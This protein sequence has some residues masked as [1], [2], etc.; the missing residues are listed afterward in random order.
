M[1]T[2]R[3]K[4]TGGSAITSEIAVVSRKNFLLSFF[5]IVHDYGFVWVFYGF[6]WI[7]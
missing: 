4:L 6:S 1:A 2:V 7:K 3:A 5:Y